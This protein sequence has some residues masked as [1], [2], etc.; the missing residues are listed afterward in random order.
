MIPHLISIKSDSQIDKDVRNNFRK[1]H[2]DP[3][4]PQK[5]WIK[6]SLRLSEI[7]FKLQQRGFDHI[8]ICYLKRL[9]Q[10]QSLLYTVDL[11]EAIWITLSGSYHT[12]GN[13]AVSDESLIRRPIS[14]CKAPTFW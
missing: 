12:S 9:R 3:N 5:A 13:L 2:F 6:Q 8:I 4:V 1:I 10:D 14:S 7:N 11:R